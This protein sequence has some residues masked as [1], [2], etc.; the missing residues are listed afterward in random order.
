MNNSEPRIVKTYF[1]TNQ[2]ESTFP[3]EFTN[4]IGKKWIVVRGCVATINNGYIVSDLCLHASF[5]MRDA[6]L[7]HFVNFV[8]NIDNGSLPDKYE[9]L[10]NGPKTFRVWFTSMETDENGNF[11][12]IVP[13][14]FILKLLLIY[15]S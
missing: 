10:E 6:Y 1:A 14:A 7:D 4:A 11:I 9:Y 3:V 8:N 15:E 12:E 13:D 2:F 5:I